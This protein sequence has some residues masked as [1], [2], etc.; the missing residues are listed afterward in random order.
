MYSGID[1]LQ[2]N[3]LFSLEV[4][5][6]LELNKHYNNRSVGFLKHLMHVPMHGTHIHYTFVSNYF[7]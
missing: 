2:A 1:N 5:W 7:F 3:I 6:N 4:K